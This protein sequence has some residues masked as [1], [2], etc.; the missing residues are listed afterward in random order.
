MSAEGQP[1]ETLLAPKILPLGLFNDLEG[2]FND[3]EG[4]FNDFESLF[5]DLESL[6]NDF[7]SL[8]DDLES[9]FN[10][11]ESLFDDLESLF[12]DLKRL[13]PV[14]CAATAWEAKAKTGQPF[15]SL[16]FGRAISRQPMRT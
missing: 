1:T 13:L 9:L 8:F 12:N 14:Y 2:L 5:N 15:L 7:E 10:D 6:F 16:R 4:L 3:F 11:L